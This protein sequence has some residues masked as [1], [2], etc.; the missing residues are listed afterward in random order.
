MRT[1]II[2]SSL[3]LSALWLGWSGNAHGQSE[4]TYY[5]PPAEPPAP[6]AGSE[7]APSADAQQP[8]APTTPT[9]PGSPPQQPL[10]AQVEGSQPAATQP[11]TAQ[12]TAGAQAGASWS[13]GTAPQ[14]E[15]S[16]A[17]APGAAAARDT[18]AGQD[19]AWRRR[20]R[21]LKL[22]N[23][24][25]GST[26]LLRIAG[27][28]SGAAG[29]F[30][31]GV[32]GE[33]FTSK[34]FLCNS[35]YPCGNVTESRTTR[36]A[37]SA[38]LSLTPVSF[39]EVFG[40]FRSHGTSNDAG[41]PKLLQALGDSVL[42][43][44]GFLPAAPERLFRFGGEV[45]MLM[46]S[47]T[48]SVGLVG[49]GL[50]LRATALATMDLTEMSNPLP[51]IAHLNVGYHLDNSGKVVEDTEKN[52]GNLP[53]TRIERFGLNINRTDSIEMGLAAEGVT[54][55]VRPF[56][57]YTMELPVNRQGYYC[58][59]NKATTRAFGD[60]CLGLDHSWSYMPSRV[61]VGVRGYPVLRGLSA[62]LAF[63][64][65]VTGTK[66]FLEELSPQAPWTLYFG[67]GY[68]ADVLERK[69]VT[70]TQ[71]VATPV[72]VAMSTPQLA[73]RGRVLEKGTQTPVVG[74]VVALPGSEFGGYTSGPQGVFVTRAVEQGT[75]TFQLTADG[76]E[77][78]P[79]TVPVLMH[80]D[81]AQPP[82]IQ[83]P[84]GAPTGYIETVCEL[85]ALPKLGNVVG[86]VTDA[87]TQSTVAG[88]AVVIT[89]AAGKEYRVTSDDSGAFRIDNLP[90][91][92]IKVSAKSD[93]FFMHN[94]TSQVEPQKDT[95]VGIQ[96]NARPKRA[97]VIVTKTQII[98]RKQINFETGS[99]V[100]KGDSAGLMEEI[101]DVFRRNPEVKLVEVQGHTDNTGTR[102]HNQDLSE[103]RANA[104]KEWLVSHGIA[105]DRLDAKGYGQ[106]RPVAP[107]VTAANRAKNRR[108][109]FVIKERQ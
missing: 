65:G 50:G 79:C 106:T 46:L 104:V 51:L 58:Y 28:G 14:L 85:K 90:P 39:L 34:N 102:E 103:R 23:N 107:N 24:L 101:A 32:V 41:Y 55:Y 91:G 4:P 25:R 108:V 36:F 29:T 95:T 18:H 81:A 12:P 83:P 68:T 64:I 78:G 67:L 99:A 35:D 62:L 88:V 19:S 76:Y 53:I 26:G 84:Q 15:A 20:L 98:I 38:T 33:W 42:G 86:K 77:P 75:Y 44:K 9:D 8:G 48:G 72:P 109:Q 2:A 21:S 69:P 27:A 63:D 56:V 60:K 7:A 94:S 93:K 92:A 49:K 5:T 16:G 40:S 66:S 3:C 73:I 61:S 54:R 70:K 96:L 43:V 71:L 13:L 89:D 10:A 37:T 45:Q 30:R 59:P 74:A 11:T 105:A 47:S 100:I 87:E 22:H 6:N 57:G 82:T 97:N 80:P 52:R 1:T 31:V 17:A